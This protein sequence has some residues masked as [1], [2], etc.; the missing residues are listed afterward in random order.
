M[1]NQRKKGLK[2]ASAYVEEESLAAFKRLAAERGT[3]MASLLR[4]FV[5]KKAE[6]QRVKEN[7]LKTDKDKVKRK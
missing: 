6:V 1:P 5:S 4:E 3:D 2:L 7:K